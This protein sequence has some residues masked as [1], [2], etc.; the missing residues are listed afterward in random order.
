[1]SSSSQ[2]CLECKLVRLVCIVY[3]Y[4]QYTSLLYIYTVHVH[5][6]T[7]QYATPLRVVCTVEK[8]SPISSAMFL[9]QPG[10]NRR[11]FPWYC[12]ESLNDK[13]ELDMQDLQ[14]GCGSFLDA[15]ICY[16]SSW[17]IRKHA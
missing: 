4:T 7:G 13:K 16:A 12:G 11:A 15:M 10:Y 17:V 8:T 3:T 9:W 5:C 1:M 14:A 2:E 6:V